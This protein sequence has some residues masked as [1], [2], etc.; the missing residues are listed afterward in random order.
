LRIADLQA[1][2]AEVERE[3]TVRRVDAVAQLQQ[4]Q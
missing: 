4:R 3:I 2:Q 1:L